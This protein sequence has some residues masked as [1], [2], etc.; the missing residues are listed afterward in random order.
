MEINKAVIPY[1]IPPLIAAIFALSLG[2][3]VFFQNHRSRVNRY[4]SFFMFVCSVWLSGFSAMSVMKHASDAFIFSRILYTAVIFIPGFYYHF[5]VQFLSLKNRGTFLKVVYAISLCFVL[6]LWTT[7]KFLKGNI[8]YFWGYSSDAAIG[9]HIFLIF[10]FLMFSLAFYE[11]LADLKKTKLTDPARSNR[12]KYVTIAFGIATIGSTDYLSTYHIDYYPLGF[13]FMITFSI[14]TSYAILKHQLMDIRVVIRKTL[15]YG[16]WTL[17][18]SIAY[19]FIILLI[20]NLIFKTD[21]TSSLIRDPILVQNFYKWSGLLALIMNLVLAKIARSRDRDNQA[22]KI[23]AVFS[24]FIGL[25]AVGSWSANI[26]EDKKIALWAMRCNYAFGAYVPALFLDFVQTFTGTGNKKYK[27]IGYILS[28]VL[29]C[30]IFTPYFVRSLRVIPE[31]NFYISNPGPFY[32]LFVLYFCVYF[33]M[34]LAHIFFSLPK[35]DEMKAKRLW[36]VFIAYIVGVIAGLEYFMTVFGFFNRPPLDDYIL[37]LTFL[38]LGYAILKHGLLDIRT[39]VKRTFFYSILIFFISAFYV[40]TIF[41]VYKFLIKEEIPEHYFLNS[42]FIILLIMLFLR[43]IEIFLNRLVARRFFSGTIEE[44][45]EQKVRLETEL[46]RRERL[47]SV[48]IL[49][50]GMAHE[51]KNPLTSIKTFAEYLPQKYD[52]PE[53]RDKF[54][55]IVSQEVDRM[56]SILKQ[57]LEFSKPSQPELKSVQIS[58]LLD[59][60]LNLLTSNLIKKRIELKKDMSLCGP[61]RADR[62]QLKQVFLNIIL[63]AIQSMSAG[64]KLSVMTTK[65]ADFIKIAIMDTGCG[66]S[67]EQLRRVFDPFYTTREEG[68]GLGLAIAYGIIERHGGKIEIQSELARGTAVNI[69]LKSP[70]AQG[71]AS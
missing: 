58:E 71:R 57:L 9:H 60:I 29:A 3:F 34:A 53:F 16:F 2:L 42:I 41:G 47:K 1:A 65:G 32:K 62:N 19:A 30:I 24:A 50:A 69:F 43:P 63:N 23:F 49:A 4:F 28:S 13:I 70:G 7:R 21:L 27:K 39:L 64:G 31:Y 40:A 17:F 48:G 59:E 5:V 26:I 15:L 51:I 36:Y 46:E 35:M 14:I 56:N 54:S 38:I 55:R 68:T 66:M 22:N 52:D 37:I 44:I 67:K 10:F 18:V 8:L 33:S 25:W 61:I 45:S 20:Q 11:L 12:I 6:T